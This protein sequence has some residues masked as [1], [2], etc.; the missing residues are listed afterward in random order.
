MTKPQKP[1]KPT[2]DFPLFPHAS[3]QWSKKAGGK[4]HYFGPWANPQAALDRYNAWLGGEPRKPSKV[5]RNGD[6]GKPYPD[7]P[8][9][10]HRT[11][12]W[13]KRIRGKLHYF[14]TDS[15]AAKAKYLKQKDDLHAG[16]KPS[17]GK[18]LTVAKLIT[19]FVASKQR[20][21]DT[22]ELSPRTLNDYD[23]ACKKVGEVFGDNQVVANLAP[24]DFATLRAA[25]A[26]THGFVALGK[27]ITETRV[28][29]KYA[30]DNKLID[31]P[32]AFGTEFKTP[33]K[34]TILKL[35]RENTE[36][37]GKRMFQAD[38]LR[39]I[40]GKAGIQLK[41]MCYLGI[42]CGFG[43][44]DCAMLP[45]S[46]LD[47]DRGWV[48]FPRPK[49]EVPRRCPLWPETVEA[50][51]AA[52]AA[53]PTPKDPAHKD[54]VFITRYRTAWEP[55]SVTDNPVSKE[56]AKVLKALKL[57]RRG[58]GFYALRHTFQTIGEKTRDG[59]SVRFIMGHS[60]SSMSATYSE[61]PVAD[62]RLRGVTDFVRAWLK[63]DSK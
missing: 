12:Q 56:M 52:I 36:K 9:Y 18:G 57:H 25:F 2:P 55:K 22:G 33:N 27:D 54:R 1:Q 28:L 6:S 31:R 19:Q 29:F 7:F 5:S 3:G 34:K 53:R 41:A 15:E 45:M 26:K 51:R 50:L 43:N 14:G 30:F 39:S 62:A 38:E 21:V 44:N 60:D 32:I 17:D 35:R 20:G 13:S 8:L 61:E 49:T 46:A 40:I 24:S 63:E 11:G 10:R 58:L 47:L 42:N 23:R 48:V 4:L 59:D 37:N 16:R